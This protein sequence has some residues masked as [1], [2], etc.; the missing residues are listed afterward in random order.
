MNGSS[1][2]ITIADIEKE[3]ARLW[4]AQ[5]EKNQLRASLFNLVIYAIDQ[6]KVKA[7]HETVNTIIEKF[8]CRIIFIERNP[9]PSQNYLKVSATNAITGKG[10]N[11]VACDQINVEVSEAQIHR[12]PFVL[13]PLFVPD[14]PIYLLWGCDPTLETVILPS[15]HKYASRVIFDSDCTDNLQ[16]FSSRMLKVIE[17]EPFEIRDINWAATGAWREVIVN[18]FNSEER[19]RTLTNAI[20]IKLTF[21][22]DQAQN[23]SHPEIQAVYIQAWLA[24]QLK[25]K[26]LSF[27][28]KDKTRE[29]VYSHERGQVTVEIEPTQKKDAISGSILS[30]EAICE[31]D[32]SF[33]FIP[34]KKSQTL[35]HITTRDWCEMPY[36]LPLPDIRKPSFFMQELFYRQTSD[37][38]SVMLSLLSK[39]N[40]QN[41]HKK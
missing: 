10:N 38:Y 9:D 28:F 29:F 1:P 40:C 39:Y 31:E 30:F 37:H 22:D 27:K 4:E 2:E 32:Q 24:T 16:S 25:W 3:L 18:V 5:K 13:L 14:L 12:I 35:I 33:L 15:I 11:T 36:A 26:F 34:N 19:L 17:K 7:L 6:D 23:V 41:N 21:N 20:K 8:P